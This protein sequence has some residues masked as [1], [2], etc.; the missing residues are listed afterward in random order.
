MNSVNGKYDA[1]KAHHKTYVRRKYSKY[2]GM[3]IVKDKPL[4]E[5]IDKKLFDDQ[6]PRAIAGRIKKKEKDIQNVSKDSIHRYIKSVY[7]RKI[8]AHRNRLKQR[9]RT[10]RGKSKKL[11]NRTFIDKRPK[12]INLRKRIGDTESDFIESGKSGK[13]I[14]L[15]VIDR[16]SRIVFIERILKITIKNVH[17]AFLKI[18]KRFPEM[19]TI[20]TDNDILLQKHKELEKLLNVKIYFCDP[21]SSWQKGT[22]EN[23]NKYIRRY[24]PKGSNISKYSKYIVKK[25]EIKMNNRFMECLNHSTPYELLEKHKKRKKKPHKC[26]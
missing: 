20:T 25:I 19:R 18:K 15:V 23:A 26:G 9:R 12:I 2:Q 24:I 6:S 3:K 1:K 10:K 7:G 4:K 5:F 14:L 13:G 8:E 16:R 22:V 11:S 17:K 21:Y